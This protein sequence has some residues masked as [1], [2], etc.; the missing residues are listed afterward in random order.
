M[1]LYGMESEDKLHASGHASGPELKK[2][3]HKIKPTKIIPIHTE[4]PEL[5]Q[6]ISSNTMLVEQGETYQ[7]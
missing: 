2:I 5:F 6:D 4:H 1:S 7:L 3:L